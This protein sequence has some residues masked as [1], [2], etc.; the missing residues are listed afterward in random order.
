MPV[1][2][3]GWTNPKTG[4]V[5]P[6][7]LQERGPLLQI[8]VSIPDVLANSINQAQGTIPPPVT[9][10][11]LLDTGASIT[12]VDLEELKKLNLNKISETPVMTPSGGEIQ[13]IYACQISF[14]GT[15]IEEIELSAVMGSDLKRQG[16]LAILGR[17]ILEKYQ[18]VYNG[19][20]GFWTIAG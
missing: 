16:L 2:N 5:D 9:G 20:G 19:P 14:P 11:G 18:L 13:G 1:F 6:K 8:E 7:V 12:G 17:D 10:F 4:R 3:G 15:Q